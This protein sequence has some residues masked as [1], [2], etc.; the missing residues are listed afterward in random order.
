MKEINI[1]LLGTYEIEIARCGYLRLIWTT[2]LF[3]YNNFAIHSGT[4]KMFESTDPQIAIKK[5]NELVQ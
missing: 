2:S 1:K 4:G 3:G 5:F